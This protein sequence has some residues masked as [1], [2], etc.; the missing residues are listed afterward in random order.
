MS[1]KKTAAKSAT[2]K[3]AAKKPAAAEPATTVAAAAPPG[4]AAAAA[5]PKAAKQLTGKVVSSKM[6]KTIAV[7]VERYVPHATYGKY[8]RRTTKLL[9]HD[10]NNEGKEGDLVAI[11]ECRPL[12]RHKSWRL[13]KVISRGSP[14][15][16]APQAEEATP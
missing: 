12:S 11:E 6:E 13:V 4:T 9:A 8:Q 1:T 16:Q 15:D 7:S 5:A 2:K 10:E 3:A 14:L